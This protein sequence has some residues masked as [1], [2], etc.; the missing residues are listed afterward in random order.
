[1]SGV[2]YFV[3]TREKAG[4][5]R[6]I[7]VCHLKSI[8]LGTLCAYCRSWEK[9][10]DWCNSKSIGDGYININCICEF[11]KYLFDLKASYSAL[12]VARSALSFFLDHKLK[13]GSD[14]HVQKLFKYFWKQ[15]PSLP[16]YLVNWDVG[17]LLT[18]LKSWHPIQ[19]LTLEQLT[20]KTVALVALTSSDR[21][22]T[23]ESID[24]EHSHDSEEAIMFPIYSLLKGS[25]RNRPVRVVKCI[26]WE[27][28][29]LNVADYVVGYLNRTLKFRLRAVKKGLPK[30]RILFLSYYTGRPIRR[31]TI[32]KYLIKAMHLAGIDTDCFKAHSYRGIGPSIMNRKGCS[33]SKIMEQGDWR[34][35]QTFNRFYNKEAENSPVDR[36]ILEVTG[37]RRY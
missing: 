15:R 36:L 32:S 34:Q 25:K 33:P 27:D 20:L 14:S 35:A 28:P 7:A 2:L 24:I 19:S 3:D 17:K 8:D 13:I 6:A 16:R 18:L 12:N 11:L 22:Q 4:L 26:K 1:M 30:P 31:A 23:L 10:A 37:K 29:S 21:A 5:P 9:F